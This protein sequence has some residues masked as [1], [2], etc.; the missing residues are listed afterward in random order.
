MYIGCIAVCRHIPVQGLYIRIY[1]PCTGIW[2]YIGKY[3]PILGLYIREYSGTGPYT[4][5]GPVPLYIGQIQAL[6]PV[7]RIYGL[8]GLWGSNLI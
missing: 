4:L 1:R 7:Y 6:Q 8:Q 3:R 5:Y 2:A